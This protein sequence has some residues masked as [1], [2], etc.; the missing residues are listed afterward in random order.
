M[1]DT[2]L[3]SVVMPSLNQAQ[4]IEQSIRS[5]LEQSYEN[6][7]LI[8]VDGLS[9]DGTIEL[10]VSLQ[11]EFSGRLQWVSQKDTGPAQALN[12]AISL[13][14]GEIIGWLNSDDLY[15]PSAIMRAVDHFDV[16]EQHQMVYGFG[17]HIGPTGQSLGEY[18]TKPPSSP[19]DTFLEGSFICQPTVF[20]RAKALQQVGVLDETIAT[21]FDFDLW[22]RFFKRFPRQIGLIRRMQ[23]CSRLHAACLTKRQR[24]QV[25]LDGVRVITK[26]LGPAPEHWFWTHVDEMCENHP[27]TAETLPLTKQLENF[28]IEIRPMVEAE[29]FK[30]FI[31]TLKQDYRFGLSNPQLFATVQP[32]GWVS[33]KVHV[34]YK[35][36]GIPA[37]NVI[38]VCNANW[39]VEGKMRLKILTPSGAI[40]RSVVDCPSEFALSFDVPQEQTSGSMMWT[41]ETDQGFVP[42]KHDNNSDDSRKLSFRV[43]GLR[44]QNPATP[45]AKPPPP[46]NQ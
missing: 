43:T 23:A 29:R 41:V 40:Q 33:K 8:V 34:K 39:P 5:V 15:L 44:L 2:P 22:V 32:D 10:L 17:Q 38:L 14:K 42:S 6:T 45:T 20:M 37:T 3:V 25:A 26:H 18:P 30:Q 13:A 1:T 11:K 27:F 36:D 9:T 16:N 7:E 21:A 31:E 19:M 12:H 28:L 35:W 24:K 4:F 46:P